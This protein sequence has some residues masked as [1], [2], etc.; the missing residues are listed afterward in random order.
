MKLARTVS[1][2]VLA[3]AAVLMHTALVADASGTGPQIQIE[4]ITNTLPDI[5]IENIQQQLP[6]FDAEECRNEERE[7]LG[8]DRPRSWHPAQGRAYYPAREFYEAI[9]DQT[10]TSL[11]AQM[12]YDFEP[13]VR[14]KSLCGMYIMANYM[15]WPQGTTSYYRKHERANAAFVRQ[16]ATEIALAW[17]NRDVPTLLAKVPKLKRIADVFEITSLNNLSQK[18]LFEPLPEDDDQG[19]VT[20]VKPGKEKKKKF[21]FPSFKSKKDKS[22]RP[23]VISAP[24]QGEPPK[25]KKKK[26]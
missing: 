22:D 24:F 17:M 20:N 1:V 11:T 26:K 18:F 7:L 6:G 19:L 13:P 16:V 15:E 2:T 12:L 23:M 3:L 14:S 25:E 8:R 9:K 4:R 5:T 10:E 21:K